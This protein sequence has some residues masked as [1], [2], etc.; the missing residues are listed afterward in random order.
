VA[1][2]A[3]QAFSITPDACYHVADVL[4]DGGSVGA[5]TGYTFPSVTANHT[6]SASFALDLYTINAS[7]GAGGSITPSG[8]VS[9]GCGADQSF[10]ISPDAGY[11]IADV[12]VDGGSVG[13]VPTYTFTGVNAGHTIVASFVLTGFPITASAGAGGAIDPS[14]AV[15]VAPGGSQSFT[16][17]PDPC[18]HIAD[19]LVDGGSVGAVSSYTFSD[20]NEAHTISASFGP[21]LSVS[22]GEVLELE[23]NSGSTD[24]TFPVTLS[25]PCTA[26]VQVSWRTADGTAT[27]SSGD[28]TADSSAVSFAPGA[29]SGSATVSVNGD[30]TPEDQET[31]QV[32]LLNPLNAGIAHGQGT[33]TILNDDAATAV[34]DGLARTVSIAVQGG[35]PA[36]DG[37]SFR[38]GL[39]S[40]TRAELSIYDVAGRR[41]AQLVSGVVPAGYRTIRWTPRG[42]GM[43]AGSGV[44]FARF[45]AGGRTFTR[46]FVLL[47]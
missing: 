32:D 4:V 14:G 39:P 10:T 37:V 22:I 34:G 33:G 43:A 24:F 11:A 17:T 9:A 5:V 41:V 16:I 36:T 20:V 23:G 45:A 7:A 35:N 38:L 26:P 40:R 30:M 6:I 19:V 28:Y 1:P 8:A 21:D 46:R 3:D 18:Y 12:L 42:E 2:G 47:K 44:Y 27:A 13:A 31:F 29:V 15:I 25:G